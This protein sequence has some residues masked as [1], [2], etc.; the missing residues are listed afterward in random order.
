M[1]LLFEE[2]LNESKIFERVI[3]L[4]FTTHYILYFK[5]HN[6]TYLHVVKPPNHWTDGDVH[7]SSTFPL[8]SLGTGQFLFKNY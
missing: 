3:N 2:N 5:I 7:F 6:R 4:H 1:A 8:N